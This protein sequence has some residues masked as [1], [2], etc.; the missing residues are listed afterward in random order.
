MHR[1]AQVE[2]R[3]RDVALAVRGAPV[4]VERRCRPRRAAAARASPHGRARRGARSDGAGRPGAPSRPAA[5]RAGESTRVSVPSGATSSSL[6]AIS[7]FAT[8][9]LD[10]RDHRWGAHQRVAGCPPQPGAGRS[11]PRGGRPRR[12]SRTQPPS[13]TR[14]DRRSCPRSLTRRSRRSSCCRHP[15]SAQRPS[16]APPSCPPGRD[17]R[18]GSGL[19]TG[20]RECGDALEW[21]RRPS[22]DV[23]VQPCVL[24]RREGTWPPPACST[25]AYGRSR[26]SSSE[27]G[28]FGYCDRIR[29]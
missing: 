19:R 2:I 4:A 13:P 25:P 28:A 24:S 29:L 15:G 14:P 7:E 8:G 9:E 5:G 10:L 1:Q 23:V 6:A 12:P 27:I 11:P 20:D 18:I 22:L 21:L 17:R 16:P 26:R 3:H